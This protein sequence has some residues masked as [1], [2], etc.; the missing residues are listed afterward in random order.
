MR[1]RKSRSA[2]ILDTREKIRAEKL[3]NDIRPRG[4]ETRVAST[5]SCGRAQRLSHDTRL[6]RGFHPYDPE[7]IKTK[8]G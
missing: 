5:V 1:N 2:P 8:K 4:G 3:G 6:G 7:F